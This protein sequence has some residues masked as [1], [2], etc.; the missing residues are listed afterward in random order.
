MSLIKDKFENYV[1]GIVWRYINVVRPA[2]QRSATPISPAF[3]TIRV[4]LDDGARL[5]VRAH[6]TDAGADLSCIEDVT[7]QPGDSALIDTGVHVELPHGTVG[8]LK[9]KSGLNCMQ[10]M[11]TTGV[12]DEGYTGSIKVRVYNHGAFPK[13]FAAGDKVTQ[14]VVMPVTFPTY[15]EA[16]RIDGGERGDSG[17]GS[18]GAN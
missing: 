16:D 10:A 2:L 18:T 9:S 4:S 11:T 5:P 3:P 7:I 15:V 1:E 13:E 14:L 17:F 8:M 12:I 6:D